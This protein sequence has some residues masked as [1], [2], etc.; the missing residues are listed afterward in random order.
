MKVTSRVLEIN[1]NEAETT[2]N[3]ISINDF[4]CN[5]NSYSMY[6]CSEIQFITKQSPF[7]SQVKKPYR[8]SL[9]VVSSN[10][11]FISRCLYIWIFLLWALI[12]LP[13]ELYGMNSKAIFKICQI[14]KEDTLY[15]RF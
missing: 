12:L 1:S 6:M 14:G 10:L 5:T 11:F 8:P 7:F 4:V 2:K 9:L 3:G 13:I 15:S